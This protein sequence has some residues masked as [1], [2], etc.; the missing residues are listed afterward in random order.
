M[1]VRLTLLALSLA[2]VAA[3]GRQDAAETRPKTAEKP[4][5]EAN[6][7]PPRVAR[8]F[9]PAQVARGKG[10][11]DRYC[12]A[13]HGPAGQGQGGEWW[14]RGPDGKF[15]PPPLDDSAH[16]WHHPT[17]VLHRFIKYGSPAGTGNMPAWKAVL[18]DAQ[19][20]DVIV[21]I[22]SL[23]SDEVYAVWHDIER[24]SLEP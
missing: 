12:A 17:Q 2:L 9:D 16:A 22:K 8:N 18:S 10:V 5:V 13:C 20:D 19:I 11:Y 6:W 24:R 23:W 4:A 7:P 14:V 3:C 15:P 21:Y 1:P